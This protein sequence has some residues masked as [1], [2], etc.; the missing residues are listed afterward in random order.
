M[1][2]GRHKTTLR[3]SRKYRSERAMKH[4]IRKSVRQ[5]QLKVTRKGLEVRK[6][7]SMRGRTHWMEAPMVGMPTQE[8]KLAL[9]STAIARIKW[10]E[11]EKRL[12]IW[13]TTG[14]VYD[15]FNV[16]EAV[17][18][19]LAQAQSKGRTFNQIIQEWLGKKPHKYLH[20]LYDYV[21][22]R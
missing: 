21:R 20:V 13:F 1:P 10:Y 7:I 19:V 3:G 9:A 6:P 14:H 16:P 4:H 17:V 2:R 18:V 11:K 22:V 12:R 15:Y 5:G 8:Q